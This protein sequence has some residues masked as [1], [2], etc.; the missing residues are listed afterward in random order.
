MSTGN[1]FDSI[2]EA[3]A[4]DLYRYAY[5]LCGN[6]HNAEDLVQETFTL[7]WRAFHQLREITAAK[8]WL[9]KTMRREHYKRAPIVENVALDDLTDIDFGAVNALLDHADRLDIESKLR[10]LPAV[11]R[12]VLLLQLLFGYSS[13]E[14]SE[15]LAISEAAVC[16]RLHRARARLAGKSSSDT[17]EFTKRV[18]K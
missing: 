16:S 3:Y 11:S 14:I 2:V 17:V 5:Y 15:L 13:Q 4:D 18:A 6:R 7:G 9:I 8:A 1:Q 12:E 10:S